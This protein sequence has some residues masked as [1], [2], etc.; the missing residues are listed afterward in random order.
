[1]WGRGKEGG[2]SIA[3]TS[4][5]SFFTAVAANI[6]LPQ[7]ACARAFLQ[8]L[9][10]LVNRHSATKP[11]W[12]IRSATH[13]IFECSNAQL[14]QI[15]E[16]NTKKCGFDTGST[17]AVVLALTGDALAGDDS[18]TLTPTGPVL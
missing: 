17:V 9:V 6:L 13:F 10:L 16:E 4:G 7:C 8:A 3:Q 15:R 12:P 5:F 1:M 2:G 11:Q 18:R 14:T